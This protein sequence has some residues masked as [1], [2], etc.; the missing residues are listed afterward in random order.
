MKCVERIIK[1][2]W[3]HQLTG[4]KLKEQDIIPLQMRGT[5]Y[6][7]TNLNLEG[8]HERPVLQA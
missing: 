3:T 2:D 5:E 4:E 1:K 6:S 8:K 7:T